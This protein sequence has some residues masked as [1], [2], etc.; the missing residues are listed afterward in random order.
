MWEK[1]VFIDRDDMGKIKVQ[2][3]WMKEVACTLRNSS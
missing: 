3:Q 2:S 1:A